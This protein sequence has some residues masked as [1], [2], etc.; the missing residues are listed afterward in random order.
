M[1]KMYESD[2]GSSVRLT[3]LKVKSEGG[4]LIAMA[5]ARVSLSEAIDVFTK[6][7]DVAAERGLD[8]ILVDSRRD[9]FGIPESNGLAEGIR[10]K[11]RRPQGRLITRSLR[12][13]VQY[14]SGTNRLPCIVA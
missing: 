2:K 4:V 11:G 13:P 3:D 6:A 8:L 12:T 10:F 7:C 9:V 14:F 5:A 1:H